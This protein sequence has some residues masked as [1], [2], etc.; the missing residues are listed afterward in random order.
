MD[1]RAE[2]PSNQ[3]HELKTDPEVLLAQRGRQAG[4]VELHRKSAG[5]A[6]R[7][8]KAR[9]RGLT[10]ALV[11]TLTPDEWVRCLWG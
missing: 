3:T 9:L 11:G 10:W 5:G 1:F 8:D 7:G 2:E 4:E 6:W